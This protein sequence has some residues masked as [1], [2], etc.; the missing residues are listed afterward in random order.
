MGVEETEGEATDDPQFVPV[1]EEGF[2]SLAMIE[3]FY[4]RWPAT[5]P[6]GFVIHLTIRILII[7]CLNDHHH[8]LFINILV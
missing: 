3:S 1:L 8:Y 4:L 6:G 7:Y 2:C 5:W